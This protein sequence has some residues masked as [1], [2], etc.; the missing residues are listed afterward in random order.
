M[1]TVETS[2]FCCAILNPFKFQTDFS[3]EIKHNRPT[4]THS[5]LPIPIHGL[6]NKT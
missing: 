1:T 4:L 2:C 5:R 3:A 6:P